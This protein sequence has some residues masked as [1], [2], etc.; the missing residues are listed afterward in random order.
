[1]AWKPFSALPNYFGGKQRLCPVI[2]REIAAVHPPRTWPQLTFIDAFMGAGSVSL[3]AK[4]QGFKVLAND[5]AR[6]CH[7]VG[8]AIIENN[9]QKLSDEDLGLLFAERNGY[10]NFVER[11]YVPH[12]FRPKV[13]QFLDKAFANLRDADLGEIH[14]ALLYTALIRFMLMIRIG[15]QMTNRAWCT[16]MTAGNYDAITPGQLK[17]SQL[18]LEGIPRRIR[19]VQQ[20]IN[21]GIFIGQAQAFQEDALTWMPEQQAD[22]VYLDPPYFG[23]TSYEANYY[24]LDCILEGKRLP[25]YQHSPFNRREAAWMSLV[26][27]F[28]AA[29][30]IP[31]WV[32]SFADNPEGFSKG[33]VC[34]LIEEFGRVPKEVP[35]QHRW[36]IAT[37]MDHYEAGAKELLLICTPP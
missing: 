10:D 17:R 25:R 33:Q 14:Q 34:S 24:H 27:M 15:G 37:G 23:S 30:H 5:L 20:H 32:F 6:R 21:G 12:T 16:N 2:F 28:D 13:A 26:Q 18:Q 35:L 29:D 8:K 22:I 19:R 4:A 3:Y 7:L 31:T 11:F 9:S 1:M 36:S